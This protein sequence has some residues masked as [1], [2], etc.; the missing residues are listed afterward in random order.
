VAQFTKNNDPLV[1]LIQRPAEQE[2]PIKSEPFPE[3]EDKK[4]DISP[5]QIWNDSEEK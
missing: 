1:F 4:V 2:T 5:G 3:T